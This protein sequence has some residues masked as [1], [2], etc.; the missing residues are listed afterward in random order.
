LFEDIKYKL[1]AIYI[2]IYIIEKKKRIEIL[3]NT[4]NYV[5]NNSAIKKIIFKL[6]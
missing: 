2:Y 1:L 6:G 5:I 3:I 4:C